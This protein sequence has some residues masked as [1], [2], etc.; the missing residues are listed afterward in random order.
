MYILNAHPGDDHRIGTDCC[1]EI[2]DIFFLGWGYYQILNVLMELIL[3][4][5]EIVQFLPNLSRTWTM[6]TTTKCKSAVLS[7]W[8]VE[9]KALQ[10][11]YTQGLR[12]YHKEFAS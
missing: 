7:N 2:V 5:R 3:I 4:S 11:L 8:S 12:S 9:E 6:E 10:K 1:L